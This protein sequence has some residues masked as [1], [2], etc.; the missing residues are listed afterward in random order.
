[1]PE[2]TPSPIPRYPVRLV[3]L[4]TGLTPHVLRAWERRYGV[5]S[6]TR[7]EGGQRLYSE[8]DIERLLRLRRL[9]ERGHAIGRLAALALSE[10]AR[11]EEETPAATAPV[12]TESVTTAASAA[13]EATRRLDAVEL[14]AV[15]ERAAMTL[16]VPVFLDY[17]VSPLLMQIGQ[18]WSERSVSVA[19]E[20]MASGVIRRVLGWLL[21]LY[22]VRNGAP[23][24]VVTTPPLHAHE[25]G[26]LMAA[27]CAAAEGWNVTYLGPDLPV[28]DLVGAVA[29]SGARAVAL[30][31]VYQ[32]E[33]GDLLEALRETRARLPPGVA[34]VVG[35]SGALQIRADAEAAGARVVGS[36][37]EFRSVLPRLAEEPVR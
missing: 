35:G 10:L 36:L 27:A 15:L 7:S 13:L 4:R 12:E 26:A 29:M 5:V 32:P 3:A 33:G 34:L 1:M 11:L 14:Q 9:T 37:A 18:R 8:L 6:P 21:R 31:A 25:F 16:G 17:V 22:E 30:S 2:S 23:R 24:V 19:Q 28:T 20:H